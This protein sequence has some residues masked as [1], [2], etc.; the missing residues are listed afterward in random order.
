[1]LELKEKI[2]EIKSQ[3]DV[4]QNHY[5]YETDP[6]LIDALVYQIISLEKRYCYYMS[7]AKEVQRIIGWGCKP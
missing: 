2:N 5:K 6:Y 7:Q 3:L 1:M 4:A